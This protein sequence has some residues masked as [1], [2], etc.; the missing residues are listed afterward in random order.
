LDRAGLGFLMVVDAD[1]RLMV[2]SQLTRNQ[3]RNLEDAREKVRA[4][5]AAALREPRRR[6][7][8]RPPAAAKE[9]RLEA[10]KH[11]AA[12]KRERTRPERW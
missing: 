8:S 2:T 7:K 11:R 9:R 5:V 10:K 1:G 6:K 4:L 12:L 3:A